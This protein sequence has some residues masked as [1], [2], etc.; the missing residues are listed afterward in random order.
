MRPAE[1]KIKHAM[2]ALYQAQ[3]RNPND[4]QWASDAFLHNLRSQVLAVWEA[5]SA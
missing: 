1:E 3:G 4:M 5:L 2:K